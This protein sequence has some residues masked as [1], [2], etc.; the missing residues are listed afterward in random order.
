MIVV[1]VVNCFWL[2][3]E[4]T[5]KFYLELSEQVFWEADFLIEA[6]MIL[7]GDSS[8]CRTG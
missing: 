5:E 3:R 7:K 4:D 6:G 2:G 8:L 1:V